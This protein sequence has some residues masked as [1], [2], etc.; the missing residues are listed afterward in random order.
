MIISRW[1][2]EGKEHLVLIV[3]TERMVG[4]RSK[5][6]DSKDIPNDPQFFIDLMRTHY[7][8][9]NARYDIDGNGNLGVSASAPV[10]ALNYDSFRTWFIALLQTIEQFWKD[11]APKYGL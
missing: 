8:V 3:A 7:L 6:L 10:E 5:L 4:M 9:S 2:I 1:E 11:I